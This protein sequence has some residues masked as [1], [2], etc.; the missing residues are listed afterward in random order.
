MLD[1]KLSVNEAKPIVSKCF[2]A[3]N[4]RRFFVETRES[5][6]LRNTYWDGGS[7]SYY[8]GYNLRTGEA[9]QL[10]LNTDPPAFGGKAEGI[11]IPLSAET[12]VVQYQISGTYKYV[13]IWAH[14]NAIL[15]TLTR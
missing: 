14:P 11:E 10:R 8:C 7:R 2:P 6:T 1:R 9:G 3:Y 13:I 5:V 15:P 12:V 4:G